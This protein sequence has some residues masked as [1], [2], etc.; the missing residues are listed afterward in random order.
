MALRTRPLASG[1][2]VWIAT[3]VVVA[4]LLLLR[5]RFLFTTRLYE[6]ADEA[7]NS[8]L[9]MQAMH[10]S[11]LHGNYSMEGFFHLAGVF[12]RDGGRAVAVP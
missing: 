2:G 1:R 4:G 12:V 9:V 3:F 10:F 5:S 6:T 8:I 11:L 7:A